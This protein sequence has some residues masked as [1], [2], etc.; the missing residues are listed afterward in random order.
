M[1]SRRMGHARWK[2]WNAGVRDDPEA[3]TNKMDDDIA[4][5]LSEELGPAAWVSCPYCGQAVELLVDAGGG[6]NQ[7]YVED[8]EVCCQP[9]AV[10]VTF[11]RQGQPAVSVTTLDD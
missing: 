3:G 1:S 5:E 8:C 10:R 2:R 11:E 7:E 4:E 9:W 6:P